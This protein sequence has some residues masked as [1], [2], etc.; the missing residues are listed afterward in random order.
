[1]FP[2]F[3]HLTAYHINPH[4]LGVMP[5]N[6]DVADLQGEIFFGLSTLTVPLA[7]RNDSA[8]HMSH[9]DCTN[10]ETQSSDVVASKL[11]LHVRGTYGQYAACNVCPSSGV[12]DYSKLECNPGAYICTCRHGGG[13]ELVR[14]ENQTAVGRE[15]VATYFKSWQPCTWDT[16]MKAP[17]TCW[18]LPV[19][20]VTGGTW[21]SLTQGGW[22]DR[23][24]ANQTTCTWRA[25]VEKVVNRTCSDNILYSAIESYDASHKGCFGRCPGAGMMRNTSDPCWIYCVYATVAGPS[26]LLPHGRQHIDSMPSALLEEAFQQPFWAEH[27]GGCPHISSSTHK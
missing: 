19:V 26:A 6:M 25:S 4:H 27:K 13:T 24:G 14:C 22:C 5:V 3:H 2:G 10:A 9:H 18:W 1:M 17:Y 12:D 7:C 21:F 20:N 23:P 8:A 15:D 16:F 11:A